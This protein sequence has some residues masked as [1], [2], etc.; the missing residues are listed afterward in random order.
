MT[1]PIG[2][3]HSKKPLF[4]YGTLMPGEIAYKQ[5]AEFVSHHQQAKL[6]GY[7]LMMRDLMPLVDKSSH[8]DLVEGFL[9]TPTPETSSVTRKSSN[10]KVLTLSSRIASVLMKTLEKSRLKSFR[11]LQQIMAAQRI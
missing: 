10:L 9:L 7:S 3:E 11:V 8:T 5:I 4:V 6:P 1:T 2:M